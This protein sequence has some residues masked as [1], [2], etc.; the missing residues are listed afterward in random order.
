[1]ISIRK[2]PSPW[3][4]VQ[5]QDYQARSARNTNPDRWTQPSG[6]FYL[7][8][9]A[10]W[11]DNRCRWHR[12]KSFWMSPRSRFRS[13]AAWCISPVPAQV[14]YRSYLWDVRIGRAQQQRVLCWISDEPFR[15]IPPARYS[16]HWTAHLQTISTKAGCR[17]LSS[18]TDMSWSLPTVRHAS[19]RAAQCIWATRLLCTRWSSA[20]RSASFL[21]VYKTY[22]CVMLILSFFPLPVPFGAISSILI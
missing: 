19:C 6:R 17:T 7:H 3:N 12:R 22:C 2:E 15:S 21:S 9:S 20:T 5:R 10:D 1:M 13:R 14:V 16:Y 11:I 4:Y 18:K 8:P